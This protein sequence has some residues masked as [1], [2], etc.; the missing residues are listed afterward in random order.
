MWLATRSL[1]AHA[2]PVLVA[3]IASVGMML[4]DTV[5]L[6]HIGAA[7]LA[8][9]AIGGGL[10]LSLIFALIGIL[11]AVTPIVA[12]L[13]GAKEERKA[14]EVLRQ[15]FLLALAL[16]VP[17]VLLLCFPE[18]V[19][20]R[21]EMEGAVAAGVRDYLW[22]L[23]WG[24]PATLCYRTFYAFSNAL[25]KPRVLMLIGIAALAIHALLAWGFAEQGWLGARWRGVSGCALSNVIIAWLAA[26]SGALYLARGPLKHYRTF[27][28][29]PRPCW[30][31]WREILRL[32]LPMGFSNLVEIT[33]FTL[34]ALLIAPLGA[35]A[36]A[37]HRIVANLS[38]L[39]YMLPLSLGIATLS[40]VGLALGACDWAR[41]RLSIRAGLW[42]AAVSS[43][44]SG[45]ASA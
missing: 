30:H 28:E 17:G 2:W 25:G 26:L 6:G 1:L 31:L 29:W 40:S 20:R 22:I 27:A 34:V 38:A 23:A 18:G 44:L 11:Q 4:V 33:A 24:L 41:V 39:I 37:G 9:V 21:G 19:L 12:H 13:H 43:C 3:Q 45:L 36:V 8:A 5:V 42:L 32:G 14:V 15:G 7:D 35:E 16:S 10:H